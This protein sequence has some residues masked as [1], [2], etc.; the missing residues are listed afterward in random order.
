MDNGAPRA[1]L[2]ARTAASPVSGSSLLFWGDQAVARDS[3]G[4]TFIALTESHAVLMLGANLRPIGRLRPQ[5]PDGDRLDR[6]VTVA[7]GPDGQLA[8]FEIGGSAV[9]FD[10]WGR[11]FQRMSSP[12]ASTIGAW[13]RRAGLVLARSPY[14]IVFTPERDDAPLLAAL[15]PGQP[16]GAHGIGRTHEAL[17]PFYIHAANAGTVAAGGDGSIYYAALGRAEIRKYDA[18]GKLIWV[19]HRPAGFDTPEPRLVPNPGSTARLRLATVQKALALGPDG[20]LYVRAAADTAGG[21]DRLDVLDATTGAWAESATLD[22]GTAILVGRR[23]AI[24]QA[25]TDAFLGGTSPERRAFPPFALETLDGDSLALT[26][27]RGD[28]ALVSFWASWCGPCR[29]ELPLVDSLYRALARPDFR[30]VG[31]SEDVNDEDGRRFARA[32]GLSFPNLLGHG[33]MRARYHYGGL[34]YS[35]LLDREGRV[36]REYYGFGGRQAFDREVAAAVRA[37]LASPDT[38]AARAR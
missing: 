2:T 17:S 5:G 22:T 23:G 24:W 34:P 10:R 29:E 36:I 19:S 12:F 13:S 21:R 16:Q 14:R 35:V 37:E 33:Q 15:D 38:S 25:P 1:F 6:P 28:A 18:A 9:L 27:L 32:L 11:E 3:A 30:V 26:D 31:I 7:A 8:A 4:D 20:R